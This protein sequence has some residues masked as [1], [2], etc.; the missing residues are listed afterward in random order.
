MKNALSAISILAI[1][2]ALAGCVNVQNVSLQNGSIIIDV[3][4]INATVPNF[5]I[6]GTVNSAL[7]NASLEITL[8]D[9]VNACIFG[10]R[11]AS[12]VKMEE[13]L[14]ENL[15][16][17]EFNKSIAIAPK[18]LDG[19]ASRLEFQNCNII[20]AK[21]DEVGKICPRTARDEIKLQVQ[22]KRTGFILAQGACELADDPAVQ[23]WD[24]RWIGFLPLKMDCPH[25]DPCTLG[26]VLIENGKFVIDDPYDPAVGDAKNFNFTNWN[27]TVTN[28]DEFGKIPV[29][30]RTEPTKTVE[31]AYAGLVRK[32]NILPTEGHVYYFSFDPTLAPSIFR[33]VVDLALTRSVLPTA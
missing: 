23:G 12:G 21:D 26:T 30:L 17:V 11:D 5:S 24:F 28:Q 2:L 7:P 3:P 6:N 18:W 1:S 31:A 4:D 13:A 32:T 29:Y 16:L 20:I 33:R 27:V 8:P 9:T 22:T 14:A 19:S 25:N 15:T 10:N